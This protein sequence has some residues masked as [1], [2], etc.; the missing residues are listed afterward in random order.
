MKEPRFDLL[1]G[2]KEDVSQICREEGRYFRWIQEEQG[3]VSQ[4][5]EEFHLSGKWGVRQEQARARAHNPVAGAGLSLNSKG[6][7]EPPKMFGMEE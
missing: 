3:P 1:L 7:G 6:A 5:K 4:A 2:K